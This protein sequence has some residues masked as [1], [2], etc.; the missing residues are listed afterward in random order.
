MS[1]PADTRA[2]KRKTKGKGVAR[3]GISTPTRIL[4]SMYGQGRWQGLFQE[5]ICESSAPGLGLVIMSWKPGS[6][7]RQRRPHSVKMSQSA[8]IKDEGFT[9]VM[10]EGAGKGEEREAS[11]SSFRGRTPE[12]EGNHVMYV[13]F[14]EGCTSERYPARG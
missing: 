3:C 2:G 1:F 12:S 14:L 8:F 5:V 13:L 11:L 6:C 10:A 7:T 4:Y 9:R